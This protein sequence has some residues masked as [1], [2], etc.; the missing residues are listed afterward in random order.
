MV[1]MADRITNLLPPPA[2]WGRKKVERYRQEARL[3]LSSLGAASPFLAERLSA[4][5]ENYGKEN[6]FPTAS[7]VQQ[8]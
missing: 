5:I 3:I 7:L 6:V 2:D 4:K 8:R 1:K